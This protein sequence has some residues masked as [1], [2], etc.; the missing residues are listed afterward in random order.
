VVGGLTS[1]GVGWW[2]GWVAGSEGFVGRE[3]ELSCLRGAL[4][5]DARVLLV[6]GDAGVGKTRFVTEG[7]QQVAGDGGLVAVWGGCLPLAEQLPLLP[8]AGALGELC[9]VDGGRLVEGALGVVPEYVRREVGR[10]VPRLGPG[11]AG[12]GGRGGGWQRERLFAGVAELL[13]AVAARSAACVVVE[14]VH[15]ADSSTLDCLTFWD[16]RVVWAR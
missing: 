13:G 10:L 8:V 11:E 14:D 5:G 12:P 7:L 3:R 9:R 1:G 2:A 6:V 15:W 4:G 16:G